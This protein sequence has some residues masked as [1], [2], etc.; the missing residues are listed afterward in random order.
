[1][2]RVAALGADDATTVLV[3][4]TEGVTDPEGYDALVAS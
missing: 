2:R 3:L 1:M 4:F